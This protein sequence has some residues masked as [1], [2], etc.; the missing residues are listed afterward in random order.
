MSLIYSHICAVAKNHTIGTN[1][2]LAWSIPEDLQFFYKKTFKKVVIMGRKTFESL[3]KPLHHRL[4][5]VITRNKSYK[6]PSEVFLCHSLKLAYTLCE[7]LDL[8]SYGKEI[9]IIGGGEIY[10]QSLPH[11]TF[12]YLTR[13]HREYSGD[14]CYPILPM[15]QFVETE[16]RDREGDPDYSFITY[17]RIS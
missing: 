16:R 2:Q 5:I 6:V 4:N 12:V 11:V 7:G 3:K 8:T 17:K 1:N 14:T 10:R 15:D 13:I 9:F